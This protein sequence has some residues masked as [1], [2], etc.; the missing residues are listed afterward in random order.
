M[1]PSV[2]LRLLTADDLAFAD[3][4]R[5]LAGWN[6]TP[7][8]WRRFLLLNPEGCFLAECD[9]APAGTA[10]TLIFGAELAWVSMMLVHPDRQRRGVGRALLTR[11]LEYLEERRIR[12]VKLD[13]TPMGKVVYDTFGFR[14]EGR[15]SRWECDRY[16]AEAGS[17]RRAPALRSWAAGDEAKIAALDREAFGVSRFNVIEALARESRTGFV[18]HEIGGSVGGY[19]LLRDGSRALY[20]GPVVA[21]ASAFFPVLMRALLSRCGERRIFWDIPDQNADA[22]GWAEKHG[23]IRQRPLIR[24]FRGEHVHRGRPEMQWAIGGP[25]WG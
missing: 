1:N 2:R 14:E 11:C 23:F 24:M 12:C 19:G 16:T 25:E 8:D 18:L 17:P 7:A 4:L 15:L 22:I 9:G 5:A 13:A 6:Q 21:S 10:T 3:E 20:A